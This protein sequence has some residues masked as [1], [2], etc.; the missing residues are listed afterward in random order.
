MKD[1]AKIEHLDYVL[2][3]NPEE[4]RVLINLL[5]SSN[6]LVTKHKEKLL[7]M[8]LSSKSSDEVREKINRE[9]LFSKN[10]KSDILESLFELSMFPVTYPLEDMLSTLT[11]EELVSMLK[12]FGEDEDI[13]EKEEVFRGVGPLRFKLDNYM[14]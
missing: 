8:I 3:S 1:E 4:N 13:S 11:K 10:T 6:K 5:T 14:K 7:K 2:D 9:L 12:S